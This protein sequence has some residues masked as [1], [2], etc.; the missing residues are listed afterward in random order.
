MREAKISGV[1]YVQTVSDPVM[2]RVLRKSGLK[3]DRLG[4]VKR[5]VNGV[6]ALALSLHCKP[7]YRGGY[8]P[9]FDEAEDVT[10]DLARA[11]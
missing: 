2:E 10:D 11:V 4:S 7:D 1:D 5:D 6:E 8:T 3:I 9:L